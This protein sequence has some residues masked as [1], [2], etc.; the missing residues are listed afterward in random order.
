MY[1]EPIISWKVAGVALGLLLTLATFLVKPL[2]VS[3][4]FVVTD[5]IVTHQVAP[6]FAENNAYLSKYGTKSNWGIGYG[7]MLV[8]GMLVGGGLTAMLLRK[9][10][11]EQDKGSMPPMWEAK[12]GPS[13]LKRYVAAFG[14]GTLLLFGA[15]LAGGCTSGHMISGISQ[16]AISS[17]IFGVTTF[18]VAILMAKLL[19]RN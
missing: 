16:L 19:Y 17:F 14:G 9:K 5:A 7:W 8:L 12:F 13:R 18:A 3:T 1:D 2:G 4:Q 6:Q 10:Q 11:P 15:R